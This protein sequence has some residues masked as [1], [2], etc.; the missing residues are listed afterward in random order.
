MFIGSVEARTVPMRSVD[1][2]EVV[3]KTIP[4]DDDYGW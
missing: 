1:D 2:E 3:F 4:D